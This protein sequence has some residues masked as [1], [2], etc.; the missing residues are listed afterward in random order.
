MDTA[1]AVVVIVVVVT[2]VAVVV[3]VVAAVAVVVVVVVAV[4]VVVV[5][6]VV[7]VVKTV[8][9]AV[10]KPRSTTLPN[11]SPC[12]LAPVVPSRDLDVET[13]TRP[14]RSSPP[15][16]GVAGVTVPPA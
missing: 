9:G 16:A 6:V 8:L 5:V 12:P 14:V 4:A 13:W 11:V 15:P 2:A 10:S 3:V 7:V 1:V